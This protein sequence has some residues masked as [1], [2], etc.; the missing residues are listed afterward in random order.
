VSTSKLPS[1]PLPR[2]IYSLKFDLGRTLTGRI[3]RLS[4]PRHSRARSPHC[5][6]IQNK[7]LIDLHRWRIPDAANESIPKVV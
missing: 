3:A 1:I 4:A 2:I 7:R 5:R 6:R